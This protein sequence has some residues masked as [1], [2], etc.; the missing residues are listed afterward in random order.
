MRTSRNLRRGRFLS[1]WLQSCRARDADFDLKAAKREFGLTRAEAEAFTTCRMLTFIEKIHDYARG[2]S[3]NANPDFL[4]IAQHPRF[5]W[6]K[7]Q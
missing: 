4:T 5:L 7:V 3:S 6:R 1:R 2:G